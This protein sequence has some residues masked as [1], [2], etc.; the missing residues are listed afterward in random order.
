M[1][2]SRMIRVLLLAIL[3]ALSSCKKTHSD[4]AQSGTVM[5]DAGTY[6]DKMAH[7]EP[8]KLIGSAEFVVDEPTKANP[9]RHPVQL[10][11][12]MDKNVNAGSS[13]RI[14]FGSRV[15][16]IDRPVDTI[17]RDGE[18]IEK[19]LKVKLEREEMEELA[20]ISEVKFSFGGKS[21]RLLSSAHL[22]KIRKYWG[23][24]VAGTRSHFVY[25]VPRS[26]MATM[27]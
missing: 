14:E 11:I 18:V 22:E 25:V 26:E 4:P 2:M 5:G 16:R 1:Q 10:V 17:G 13:F 12:H 27:E 19:M 15:L 6:D 20:K 23:E 7:D 8:L 24:V 9:A 3:V 21:V